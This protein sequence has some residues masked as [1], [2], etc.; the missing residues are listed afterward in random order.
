MIPAIGDTINNR[1]TLIA[2]FR[3][4]PGLNAWLANDHTLKRDCQLYIVSDQTKLTQIN[5]IAST[6]VL[7]QSPLFTPVF[8][9]SRQDG[10]LVIVTGT[11]PGVSLHNFLAASNHKPLSQRAIRSI[12]SEIISA[13]RTL[14]DSVILHNGLGSR[15]IRLTD[16]GIRIADTT[17]SPFLAPQVDLTAHRGNLEAT[18]VS[19]IAGILFE[20]I[21]GSEYDLN[22]HA[23]MA[24]LLSNLRGQVPAEFLA[25]CT[26]GLGFTGS[27]TGLETSRAIVP[28]LTLNELQI[29]VGDAPAVKELPADEYDIPA[30]QG[31]ASISTVPLVHV[32]MGTVV[33]IPNSLAA[34]GVVEQAR[35]TVSPW[36]ASDLLFNGQEAVQE[37]NPTQGLAGFSS[38]SPLSGSAAGLGAGLGAAAA[39]LGAASLGA[40]GANSLEAASA[41]PYVTSGPYGSAASLNSGSY[42]AANSYGPASA[43]GSATPG[44]ATPGSATPGST[45]TGSTATGYPASRY[46]AAPSASAPG[47]SANSPASAAQLPASAGLASAAGDETIV[48]SDETMIS[49]SLAELSHKSQAANPAQAAVDETILSSQPLVSPEINSADETIISRPVTSAASAHPAADETLYDAHLFPAQP[50]QNAHAGAAQSPAQAGQPGQFG[51]QAQL[52]QPAA[53]SAHRVTSSQPVQYV[54]A[55]SHP[56]VAAEQEAPHRG[57][58]FLKH[59]LIVLIVVVILAAGAY[60]GVKSL[61]LG[62]F[63]II[64]STSSS[65]KEKWN[66]DVNDAPAIDQRGVP[67]KKDTSEEKKPATSDSAKK[68][69]TEKK[70]T[71]KTETSGAVTHDAKQATG[72]PAPVETTPEN[73]NPY[74][75]RQIRVFVPA[76]T[77]EAR[78]IH[79]QLS[80]P[81]DVS[82]ITFSLASGDSS[83]TGNL[84][85]NSTMENPK[86]GSSVASVTF[87]PAGK[88]TTVQF[89]KQHTQDLVIYCDNP[90]PNGIQ[91]NFTSVK[92][93]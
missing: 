75:I 74:S 49:P 16:Q 18:M 56:A 34:A 70:Q 45:A 73:T 26:R 35:P 89:S 46:A 2:Q 92:V 12:I 1:Y 3:S 58:T 80:Q 11:E 41:N 57:H 8:T 93:Y 25:I 32:S 63:S 65:Q 82:R 6:L 81:E 36:R 77:N 21:T 78:A 67:S 5:A 55:S 68:S 27:E 48:S 17:V 42:S 86:N 30:A 59:F 31:S 20:M 15:V 10:V 28:I 69:T 24:Q 71:A 33:D 43:A 19:Q 23:G 7:T 88:E 62:S 22:D 9:F 53:S 83:F 40:A 60:Y 76:N 54:Q 51:A 79:I 85:V 84:Y 13:C 52:G 91:M 64:P 61:G 37:V 72:V 90:G 66:L 29:L 14:V 50:A 38:A 4:H 39:G 47:M 87:Q 44:S